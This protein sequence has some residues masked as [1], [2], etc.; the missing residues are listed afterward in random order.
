[1]AKYWFVNLV[2]EFFFSSIPW[3]GSTDLGLEI[4]RD[5]GTI[6]SFRLNKVCTSL[7][8]TR[9][10]RE[11]EEEWRCAHQPKRCDNNYMIN[12]IIITNMRILLWM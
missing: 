11:P 7:K 12:V 8:V 3:P 6:Y 5:S 2:V 10:E 1:M 4:K 9:I